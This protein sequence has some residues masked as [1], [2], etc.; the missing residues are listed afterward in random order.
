MFQG[1]GPRCARY[2]DVA[3]IKS[4]LRDGAPKSLWAFICQQVRYWVCGAHISQEC[5]DAL[6]KIPCTR[7]GQWRG[8]V[9]SVY[10]GCTFRAASYDAALQFPL[11]TGRSASRAPACP[12]RPPVGVPG[13]N[14]RDG[15]RQRGGRGVGGHHVADEQQRTRDQH[16]PRPAA[17]SDPPRRDSASRAG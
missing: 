12:A 1:S 4:Q 6:D 11:V 14:V 5:L 15:A 13:R 7:H 10:Y 16:L 17:A 3:A 2:A 8:E 9:A